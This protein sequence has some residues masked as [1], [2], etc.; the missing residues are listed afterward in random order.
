[1][2]NIYIILI[3]VVI[4]IIYFNVNNHESF[5][6]T[7]CD[8]YRIGTIQN[9][10]IKS[11]N[12]N[13]TIDNNWN[14]YLP[15]GYKTIENQLKNIILNNN[16]KYIF[17]ISGSDKI[18]SKNNLW[19]LIQNKYSH[20]STIMPQ[21]YIL[22]DS[23]HMNIFMKK[24]NKKNIYILKKNLQRKK[25]I[26]LVKNNLQFILNA[27]NDNYKIVQEYIH[28]PFL[29]NNYK[30]NIRIFLLIVAK[31]GNK[32]FYIYKNGKCLYTANKYKHGLDFNSNITSY[33]SNTEIYRKN[34]YCLRE[35]K[36]YMD[37]N[38]MN[39][40]NVWFKIKTNV[41]KLTLA[42]Q[43]HI[44]NMT[45]L[46]KVTTFQLFGLDVILDDKLH[47]YILEINKGPNMMPITKKDLE[48]KTNI[49]NDMYNIIG[50]IDKQNNGFIPL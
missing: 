22:N 47:P 38:H 39:Y 7:K 23:N 6:Y 29:V 1:M 16:N 46:N 31:N 5:T 42:I 36:F 8:K 10:I 50:I 17:G 26:K 34:P 20:A 40:D 48:L 13:K 21:T 12:F 37:S 49:Y 18:A 35:L 15:C 2:I 4:V 44:C 43:P 33:F 25:G 9:K 19:K 27:S 30:L 41:K 28:N 24:Y 3:T 45:K 32:Y 14:L 11:N